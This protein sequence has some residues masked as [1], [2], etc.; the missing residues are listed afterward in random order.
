[1]I[2]DIAPFFSSLLSTNIMFHAFAIIRFAIIRMDFGMKYDYFRLNDLD[3]HWRPASAFCNPCKVRYDFI[4][5]F[6]DLAKEQRLF[7]NATGLSRV[8]L[9]CTGGLT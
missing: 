6:E 5:R 9:H 3:V 7:L 8:V 1:M 2:V 4:L